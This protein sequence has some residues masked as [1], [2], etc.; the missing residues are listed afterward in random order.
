MQNQI[1][2]HK[3][4]VIASLTDM[5][6]KISSLKAAGKSI[7]FVPTLGALHP[8]HLSL[9]KRSKEENDITI[10]SIYVNPTQFNK[11]EDLEKYPRTLKEDIYLLNEA[12]CN[13]IFT[14]S[15]K[16]MY[17]ESVASNLDISVGDLGK[18]ME[19]AHRPGHFEGVATIV[20]RFFDIVHPNNAYFGEKDFQQL[21]IIKQVTKQLNYD[22]TIISCPT[23]REGSGLAMSS[24]NSRLSNAAKKK[25]AT[26][27]ECLSKVV[28]LQDTMSIKELKEF[29]KE[30]FNAMPEFELEYFEIAEPTHLEPVSDL[31][32]TQSARAFI[33]VWIE[34]IR[35]IDNVKIK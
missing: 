22:I 2:D 9:I 23:I 14:P 35:L 18:T 5:Q 30:H 11:K 25:A 15:T 24:R 1:I 12:L 16:D 17:P 4:E 27:F 28:L 34:G 29:V 32:K 6:N 10:C 26:I 7:G 31:A 19:G 21:S 8:G 3:T 20:A 33:A 13:I